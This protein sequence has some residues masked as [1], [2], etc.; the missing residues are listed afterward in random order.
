VEAWV[1][2]PDFGAN[3]WKFS[4]EAAAAA[5][6]EEGGADQTKPRHPRYLYG[7]S[8]TLAAAKELV[9]AAMAHAKAADSSTL[10]TE[11]VVTLTRAN[12]T[13]LGVSLQG[14]AEGS[15]GLAIARVAPDGQAEQTGKIK[16]GMVI[17]TI[18]GKDIR[19][20]A[21]ADARAVLIESETVKVTFMPHTD[22]DGMF[23]VNDYQDVVTQRDAGHWLVW[24]A[25]AYK[26]GVTFT[27]LGMHPLT[28]E[29]LVNGTPL[30]GLAAFAPLA[31]A[32]PH[33]QSTPF[34]HDGKPHTLTTPITPPNGWHPHPSKRP[35]PQ[36][37]PHQPAQQQQ[38]QPPP[39]SAAAAKPKKATK[40]KE[41]APKMAKKKASKATPAQLAEE[42]AY[43]SN[44]LAQA[45]FTAP[46]LNSFMMTVCSVFNLAKAPADLGVEAPGFPSDAFSD[47]DVLSKDEGKTALRVG[48]LKSVDRCWTKLTEDYLP[49]ADH[50][51]FPKARYVIDLIRYTY[52]FA[53]PLALASFFI[54]L[55]MCPEIKLH[56]V[57]N[58]LC[59]PSVKTEQ[60]TV[61][62]I[63]AE[64]FVKELDVAQMFEIQ[65]TFREFLIIKE[66]L[67]KYYEMVRASKPADLLS[68]PI[69][70]VQP[71][72][73][74]RMKA[75][76][77]KLAA[78]GGAGGDAEEF[79]GFEE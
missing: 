61:V 53:S 63:N 48:P 16:A 50:P 29:W 11:V 9:G 69:F 54:F 70:K 20:M 56:R 77:D 1:Q 66:E 45:S 62:L 38:Q 36:P 43:L 32:S 23:L 13:K 17:R 2:T 78:K 33:K 72:V 10:S 59:D 28:G 8:L 49:S 75:L 74:E 14:E 3:F 55:S 65:L 52:E 25:P 4:A 21:H 5:G 79:G 41:K 57:K 64:Y 39:P 35:V 30:D 51:L 40:K 42:R 76:Q 68:H 6:D 37:H 24:A 12:G 19:K 60:Q 34:N 26:N 58:K 31:S 7:S 44:S 46:Y 18:N 27:S 67:H 47:A 71:V 73:I 15:N 22:T